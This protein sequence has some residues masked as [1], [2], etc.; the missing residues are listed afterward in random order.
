MFWGGGGG[1]VGGGGGGVG[2]VGVGVIPTLDTAAL[3]EA[4]GSSS[5]LDIFVSSEGPSSGLYVNWS[6]SYWTHRSSVACIF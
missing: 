1:G 6:C 2:G 4:G 5:S 3:S